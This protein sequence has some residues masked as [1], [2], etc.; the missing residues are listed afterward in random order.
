MNSPTKSNAHTIRNL[1]IFVVGVVVLP[2]LGWALDM[3]RGADPHNQQNSLGWLLFII[4]P[5]VMSLLLRTVGGSGWK[6]AG[7]KPAF[8]GN[9]KWYAFSILFHPVISLLILLAG[10]ALGLVVI[11]DQ[12]VTKLALVGQATVLAILPALVK[13]IFEEFGW[14]GF[15]EP[16]IQLVVRNPLLGHG[17][18]GLVWFVWHLPYYLVLLDP[19]AIRSVAPLGLAVFLPLT[20]AGLVTAALVYGEIRLL[21]GSIWPAVLMHVGGNVLIG[22]LLEQ[23]YFSLPGRAEVFMSPG[24][25]S[26][27]SSVLFAAVGLWLYRRRMAARRTTAQQNDVS[28]NTGVDGFAGG[29][30]AVRNKA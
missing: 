9:G 4:S 26:V 12:S 6:D 19:A 2:W 27:L 3:G 14:R 22:A 1:I 16:K 8:K 30:S 13:N 21:T 28:S 25:S 18:V 29:G 20:L 11:P 5:L 17:L 10:F 24:W 23:K 15:L 7:L